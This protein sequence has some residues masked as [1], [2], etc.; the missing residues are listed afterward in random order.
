MKGRRSAAQATTRIGMPM[1]MSLYWILIICAPMIM[2]ALNFFPSRVRRV[3]SHGQKFALYMASLDDSRLTKN[4]N[5]AKKLSSKKVSSSNTE[6]SYDGAQDW[7]RGM[8][9]YEGVDWHL[10][11]ARRMLEGPG[12]APLRMT[13][14]QPTERTALKKDPPGFFDSSKIL[15]NN[16]LQMMGLAKSLDGAPLVQ[17]VNTFKGSPLQLLSRLLDG[18]LQEL[19]GGPLFL[20]LHDYYKL[21]GPVYK[22]AFGPKSFIV[23]SD[24][25][26]VKHILKVS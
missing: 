24:P 5:D 3:V 2:G 8:E 1:K 9:G 18:N 17:G 16:A 25:V 7:E 11:Q 6:S 20:L 21:Y 23:V 12:F 10:E 15:L 4:E 26:M 19:A 22:L 13:L 14:W